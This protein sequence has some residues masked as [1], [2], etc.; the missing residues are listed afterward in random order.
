MENWGKIEDIWKNINS[1]NSKLLFK[2]EIYNFPP[3]GSNY[4]LEMPKKIMFCTSLA[5]KLFIR[6]LQMYTK[7]ADGP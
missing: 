4:T 1:Q 5:K 7:M 3:A 2:A 6:H